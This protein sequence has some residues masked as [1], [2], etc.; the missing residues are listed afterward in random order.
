MV[1][2]Q[3]EI[4]QKEVYLVDRIESPGREL[5]T[6]L[7]AVCFLRP[8]AENMELLIRELKDPKYGQYFLCMFWCFVLLRT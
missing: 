2:T 7:K 6:H 3:T 8:T 5:M 1:Y 4:L